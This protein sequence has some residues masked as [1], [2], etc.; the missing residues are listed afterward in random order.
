MGM[1]LIFATC[2]SAATVGAQQTSI[3]NLSY[4]TGRVLNG[5]ATVTFDLTY[6][7]LASREVLIAFIWDTVANA[8]AVG[9]GASQPNACVPMAAVPQ[10]N[11]KAVCG[12]LSASSS[13]TEHLTFVLQLSTEVHTYNFGAAAGVATLSGTAI[14]SAMSAQYFTIQTGSQ[15]QLTV[16]A[17]SQAS[18]MIDGLPVGMGIVSVQV[19]TGS[20]TVSV[21][22]IITINNVTRLKFQHW[23]DGST[24]PNRTV[25][26]QSGMTVQATYATQCALVLTSP[27][28]NATGAGWYDQGST[29]AI[30]APSSLPV[31]GFMGVLGA[32]QQFKGWF[33]NDQLV[34]ASS[35]GS[36]KMDAGHV[37]TP[38]WTID[39]TTPILVIVVIVAVVGA[40]IAVVVRKRA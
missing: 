17:P 15:V 2:L 10:L 32:R 26:V 39:Y 11:G 27:S 25:D 24:D 29:A 31:E 13:G 8:F 40:V 4:P 21:P 12:W 30:S 9:T 34:L 5:S 20:N 16:K 3:T 14:T 19:S 23:E 35:S 18:I 33:E 28:V 1:L 36:I 38:Q 6:S 22:E 37:L 7:G